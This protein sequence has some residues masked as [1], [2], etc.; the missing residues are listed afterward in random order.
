MSA[1]VVVESVSKSF[2]RRP[3]SFVP[4]GRNTALKGVSLQ[5]EAGTVLVLLG[6]NGSGKTTLLKLVS[7]MLYP[8]SGHIRVRG[9][10]IQDDEE[11]VRRHVGFAV[12]N[13]RSFFA[14]LTARENLEFFAALEDLSPAEARHRIDE[15]LFRVALHGFATRLVREY[16]AGMYQ[17]LALARALLKRP[18]V[19]L[20][21]EP[22]RS[23]DP[24]AAFDLWQ[25]VREA[26]GS[27][28]AV[29]VTSHSFEEVAQVADEVLLLVRGVV[30]GRQR[31]LYPRS[32]EEVRS[33]YYGGLEAASRV[34]CAAV[35]PA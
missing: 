31:F 15:V 22:S 24:T 6:P 19:L 28:A 26:A 20:L 4:H 18:G 13:E 16:S 9:Y 8:D 27:G 34:E 11:A 7:S 21:D 10:D 30:V 33:F 32:P 29:I 3:G 23:L 12:A 14:R 1:T 35:S 2:P 17:R 5:V 25:L